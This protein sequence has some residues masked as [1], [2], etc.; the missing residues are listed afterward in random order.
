MWVFFKEGK[1]MCAIENETFFKNEK[2]RSFALQ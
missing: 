1:F 2:Y